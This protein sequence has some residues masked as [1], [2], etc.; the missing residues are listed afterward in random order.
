[1][2]TVGSTTIIGDYYQ[3]WGTHGTIAQANLVNKFVRCVAGLPVTGLDSPIISVVNAEQLT[4]AAL[5]APDGNTAYSVIGALS[6]G[7]ASLGVSSL[8]RLYGTT[9][10]E[11]CRYLVSFRGNNTPSV[12]RYDLTQDMWETLGGPPV[13]E[14]LGLGSMFTYNGRDRIYFTTGVTG[15]VQ[16]YD[17]VLNKVVPSSTIPYAHGAGIPGARMFLTTTADLISDNL[18]YLYVMRHSGQEMWRTLIY[19]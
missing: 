10:L 1:M 14:L 11:K 18:E 7:G 13:S 12:D 16:Y 6:R 4:V 19:W 2:G 15:R 17:F 5:T 9:T 8:H 3:N